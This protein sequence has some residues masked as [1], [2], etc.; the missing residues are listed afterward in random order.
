MCFVLAC[1]GIYPVYRFLV[2]VVIHPTPPF[3]EGIPLKYNAYYTIGLVFQPIPTCEFRRY[4][5]F[6]LE[7]TTVMT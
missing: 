7:R 6:G 5:S 3:L 2:V 1:S 4:A